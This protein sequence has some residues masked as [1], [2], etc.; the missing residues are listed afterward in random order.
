[1]SAALAALLERVMLRRGMSSIHDRHKLSPIELEIFENCLRIHYQPIVDLETHAIFAHEALARSS[2][3][4]F[5]SP[6]TMFESA[7]VAGCCGELGRALR[8]IAIQESPAIPLFVNVNPNEFNEGYLVRPDEPLFWHSESVYLEITESVPL[9]HFEVC[10]SILKEIRS[11]GVALVVDDLGAGYSNL[12]YIS[13]LVPE[14]VKLDRELVAGVVHDSRQH[15]LVRQ[16]VH[17]C[18]EMGARVV[19]EGIE[20]VDELRAV[21]D[22]G[23]HFGQG[24]LL[25]RPAFPPPDPVWPTDL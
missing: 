7:M 9:S 23:A 21:I 25:A 11:K 3:S 4:R 2:S 20:T 6:V 17:L 8:Q 22:A 19:C 5:A 13:D 15:R 24:Y 12:K 1:M 10:H 16:L 18:K 14:V